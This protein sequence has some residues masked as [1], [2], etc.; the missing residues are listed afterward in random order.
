[1]AR[2][3]EKLNEW[4]RAYYARR[5]NQPDYKR[6]KREAAKRYYQ[7]NKAKIDAKRK[8]YCEKNIEKYREYRR[9][10]K[11]FNPRGIFSSLKSGAKRR[12]IAV[13]FTIDEFVQWWNYYNRDEAYCHYCLRTMAEIRRYPDSV[14][15]RAKRLTIDRANNNEPYTLVNIR[16][17][18]YRCNSI[19]GDYFSEQEMKQIGRIIKTIEDERV[20]Q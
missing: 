7:Q 9:N 12:G 2:N 13:E 20:H 10:Y 4:N 1:M 11:C 16:P 18:C 8:I 15:E 5:K 17:S 6:K 14:N 19:K 3:K